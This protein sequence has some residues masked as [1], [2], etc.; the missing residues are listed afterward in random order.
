MKTKVRCSKYVV[1]IKAYPGDLL[2]VDFYRKVKSHRKYRL[3][4][5]DFK[6]GRIG[7]TVLD[8]M[9]E[10]QS[11]TGSNTYGLVAAALLSEGDERTNKRYNVYVRILQRK[12]DSSRYRVFGVDVNSFI[13]VIP[14]EQE[15][16]RERIFLR[17]G[18]IFAE[19]N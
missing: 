16:E 14:T 13:F 11:E 4:S 9:R 7:A 12:V 5:G 6:F 17:Y 18:K 2:T 3:L 15:E 10:V 8:I 19:T 1:K